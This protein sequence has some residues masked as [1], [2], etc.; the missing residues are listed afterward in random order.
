M[1]EKRLWLYL[2]RALDRRPNA[3]T[4]QDESDSVTP[5]ADRATYSCHFLLWVLLLQSDT[6]R[7]SFRYPYSFVT[8][9]D[10]LTGCGLQI[11]SKA[12]PTVLLPQE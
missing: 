4:S 9:Y 2:C 12:M 7:A 1:L 10:A 5:S 8:Q 6:R 11:T 3:L